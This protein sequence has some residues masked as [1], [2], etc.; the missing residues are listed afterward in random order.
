M[1]GQSK[2]AT[3]SLLCLLA[4][5]CAGLWWINFLGQVLVEVDWIKWAVVVGPPLLVCWLL[6]FA[7]RASNATNRVHFGIMLAFSVLSV[8]FVYQPWN[9]R[10]VFVQKLS[11][12]HEGMTVPD[13]QQRMAGY[14]GGEVFE[15]SGG[16]YVPE[17]LSGKGVTH[18]MSYRW[19]ETDGRF[20]ADIGQ[21]FLRDGHVVGTR[22]LP[23]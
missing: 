1:S 7:L 10:R 22:F 14:F 6:Y 20:N 9:P 5:L 16:P 13:V 2:F 11:G 8:L 19:N 4:V 12:L 3:W 17:E 18:Q 21:V 23:D 15:S